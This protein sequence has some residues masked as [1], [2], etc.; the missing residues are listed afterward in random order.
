MK[1]EQGLYDPQFEHDACGVGFV[2]NINGQHSHQIVA[3]G[4]TILKNLAH[5]GA[6]GGDSKTGDGAGMLVQIPHIFFERE[7]CRLGITLPKQGAYGAG[8][9]FLPLD[10]AQRDT[11][12]SVVESVTIAE[13][14]NFLGWRDVPV[15]PGC[16]GEIARSAMPHI[17]QFFVEFAD[18]S[19]DA[20]ERR[21]YILRKSIEMG[22]RSAGFDNQDFYISSLSAATIT[23]KGMFVAAQ[24][25]AFYPDLTDP[26]FQSALALIHQRY[27][28][29]TFPSWSLA[30]PF[31]YMAH[32][33]EINTLRGNINK[34][35]G[36]E[37]TI[38]SPLFGDEI[39]KLSPVIDTTMSD[40]GIFDNVFELL[41]QGGRSIEHAMMMMVP[42]AFGA[43][44]HISEDKRAFY[45]YHAAIMEPWDGP[46]AIAF[47]DGVKIGA[48]LDRNGLRPARYVITKGGKVVMAS[49]A[50]VLDIPP[51]DVLQKGRLAPGKMFVVDTA[52]NRIVFDNEIKAS[53]SRRKQYRRWLEQ[54]RI[55]L[56]GLFQAPGPVRINRD[57]LL[58]REWMFGYS[59]EEISMVVKTMAE[60]GQEPV[61]SMG[62]DAALAVLSQRSPLLY[63]YFKQLFAQVTNP[64]IDP[65]RE[66]LV[67]SLMSFIGRE[68]NLLDETPEHAN[69][70][71]L[72]HPILSNEDCDK[73]RNLDSN[74]YRSIVLPMTFYAS[75]G[76]GELEAA[77]RDLCV[78]AERKIDQ[79]YSFLILSDREASAGKAPIPA[80]LATAAVHHHLVKAQKRQ[81]AG[82]IVETG[83]ARD[84][85]HF[86]TL[87]GYGAS[88]VNPY[89][90]F[91]II[92]DL[93]ERH[94]LPAA[95][96]LE[97]AIENY[98]T[99][100]KKG[101]LKIMSKM[102]VSTIRSYRGA[103]IFEAVGLDP[104]FVASYFPGTS[105]R[106][107]GV[108]AQEIARETLAR[109]ADA[110]AK[111]AAELDVLDSGG[112]IH[113]RN[114]S[115]KHLL[116]P[117]AVTLIQK[118][119]RENRYDIYKQYSALVNDSGKNLCTLRGLFRFRQSSPVAI[120]E[121]EPVLSI[122]KR[123]VSSAMSLGS[124]SKEAHETIAIA[125][126]RLGA[127]S[128]SGEGGEDEERYILL[129]NG[130]SKKSAIK[131]VASARFGVTSNYL[132][133]SRELQIKMA[134]GAK[135]GEGGQLPGHKVDEMIARVR[136]STPGVM[137]IS[138]PPHHDIYS[139]EDLAQLIYDLKCAN[140]EARVSVKLVAQAGVGT[141]A[142]GVAK[143]KADMVLISGHDGG[144]G[145][146]PLSSIK[147][148]G[149]PWEIGLADTQQTLILN[150]LRSR[151]RIQ[152]DGQMKTGR[153]VI[154]GA[155]LGAEE[156]GFG[157]MVLVSLG[158]IMMRKCH[159]NTCPVGVATQDPNLRCLFKGQPEHVMNFMQFIAQD[160][161][162]I[163]ASLGF[164][165]IDEMVG[166]ADVLDVNTAINHWKTRGLDFSRLLALPEA[167]DNTARRCTQ[168]QEHDFSLALDDEL[169]AQSK[170][171]LDKKDPVS[172][173]ASIRNRNRTVGATLSAEVSKRFGSRGLPTDTIKCKFTGSA[174]QSFGAFLAP[175]ITFELEGD[176]ND[177]FGK[178]LSGGKIIVYPPKTSTFRPQNNIITGNV[179]L[180]G[181]TSGEV[182]INGM[183]GER[184]A[185]RNSGATA[186]VEG[187]GDH[188]CEYMT[189]GIVV[190]LGRT[191][192]NFAAGMSGGIAYVLDEDQ[193][194]DTMCN[195]EMVDIEPVVAKQDQELLYNLICN[196]VRYTGSEYAGRI[197]RDWAALIPQFVR[198]MP[199]EYRR[200]LE[201]MKK[202]ESKE[203]DVVA[204]TEEVFR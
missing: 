152:V 162:E 39:V 85:M 61:I 104:A 8:M 163:M 54:N 60:N 20:L 19:G 132:I 147:Y 88:A 192:I 159:L 35:T 22:A 32:N 62:N 123:F 1:K 13:G 194:F 107:G 3:D 126:N 174:G 91:E 172:L 154:I 150:H 146:S 148:A 86:A 64:P 26:D 190:V 117:Q 23:Y 92:A 134:Q 173:F 30:Q 68:R 74:G 118:A 145:A 33:G 109:H 137:L 201:R 46:A 133:N 166:R 49:E 114:N 176:A 181:A 128:N 36:R 71:K 157:T 187:V 56:K 135:P 79:G 108:G 98:I 180:F 42:E 9:I 10:P 37:K 51:E 40:S 196:H 55:E 177:Y 76:E 24:F 125:M 84:V 169:I 167:P 78:N 72:P 31:R 44:Y 41:A 178:G 182:Y 90:A 25:G 45:E 93:K 113:F 198:V 67:M 200:A 99:S 156:F 75:M 127:A 175:G 106:I 52:Q 171:S 149:I 95:M 15:N 47:T 204:L 161:R 11:A 197:V 111:S 188:A 29:N 81:L 136:H 59:R 155:L 129:P 131:Q 153:D 195:L 143:G 101:L 65:Y 202:A 139:I 191:G 17:S 27:S 7:C 70:L 94:R 170:V 43:K 160:V 130:D 63:N 57:A 199:T 110:F 4:I 186:V 183:A 165:T 50:G 102:G 100:V 112:N 14:G 69:Q 96:K 120:D 89:L 38:S 6:V 119:V 115:E 2:V 80:L 28:T 151:I 179:N 16:L 164:R 189:G 103:Q 124:I 53:V 82:I 105:S 97:T 184:F 116:S 185:V 34:M 66:N 18:L 122:V 73:L 12:R 193:L 142:A 140:R 144:T 168:P 87:L 83:E 21:L 138:P 121:V 203:T 58:A 158:C 48:T 5:R 77:L 141:V